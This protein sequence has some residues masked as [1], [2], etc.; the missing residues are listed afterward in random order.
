MREKTENDS[1]PFIAHTRKATGREKAYIALD[2]I[3][4]KIIDL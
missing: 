3:Y 4:L 1:R 2:E